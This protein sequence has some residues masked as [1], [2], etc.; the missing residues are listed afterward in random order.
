MNGLVIMKEQQAVTT[1]LQVAEG[2][3]KRHT[4]VIEA[5]ENKFHSAENS[6]KYESMF[7]EGSYQDKSGKSNKMYYMNRDGFAFIAFGFTGSKADEFKLKYIE[8]FNQMEN[9]IKQQQLDMSNLSPE[10]QLMASLVNNMAKQE[11]AQK[12]LSNKVD[13]ISEIVAL[14]TTDWRKDA[15]NLIN[16][17]VREMGNT[18]EAH[19]EIRNNIFTEVDRRGGVQL[20]T[21]LTNKRRRMA[22]EGI[23]KSK[24]DSLS[25]VDV[26]SDDKKLVEIYVAIVKEY[27]IKYG[28]YKKGA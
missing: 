16:K 7:F 18:P 17:I 8:A 9:H 27:A 26:I 6:A 20:N 25:K 12:E 2:F 15:Q 1:S 22:D 10:L 4:H 28:V 19:R 23:S 11:L 5:I 14:N 13:N 24:R 3:N 21:R